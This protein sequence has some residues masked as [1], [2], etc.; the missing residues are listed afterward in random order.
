MKF[1]FWIG[2]FNLLAFIY[3]IFRLGI[4]FYNET[5]S[6][7]SNTDSI[8]VFLS[9]QANQFALMQ[10]LLS[11]LG[12]GLAVAGF[13]GYFTIKESA[14]NM[15]EATVKVEVPNLFEEMLKKYG[16]EEF[17]R[18][19]IDTKMELPQHKSSDDVFQEG[20]VRMQQDPMETPHE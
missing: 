2:G 8:G 9:A 5:A 3:I 15:A 14:K 6:V 13:W 20:I 10:V 4:P 16:R 7:L 19:L 18:F 12:I 11:A 17:Q 1:N